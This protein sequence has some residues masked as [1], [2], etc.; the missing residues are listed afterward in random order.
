MKI[1][2]AGITIFL[3]ILAVAAAGY[4]AAKA[5]KKN[6]GFIEEAAESFI[7]NKLEDFF[8]LDSDALDGLIDLTPGSPENNED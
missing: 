7:E 6:D 3:V 5:T 1:K 4:F 8:D 2:D